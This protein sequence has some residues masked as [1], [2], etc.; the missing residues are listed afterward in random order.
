MRI[1]CGPCVLRPWQAG[2][3]DS[4]VRHANDAGVAAN[5]RD[6]FPHP[7]TQAHAEQWLRTATAESPLTNFAIE[8]DG[9]AVGGIGLIVGSDI[10]KCSAEVGYWLG[11][12]VW[13]RGLA[14]AALGAITRYALRDL[15]LTRVF[16]MAFADHHASIRVL[17]K[18][19]YRRE[20]LLHRS[21]VKAGVVRDQVLYAIT[22]E[23][24]SD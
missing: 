1:D 22:D 7:Y 16:A 17:E 12:A 18:A 6:R 15:R 19:G 8:V 10:E 2:D 21:A 5:L 9:Q 20:G 23:D 4:L 24:A 13:G 14:T 11:R 3:A